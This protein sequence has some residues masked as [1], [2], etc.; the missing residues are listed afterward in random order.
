MLSISGTGQ[1]DEEEV[2]GGEDVETEVAD[3]GEREDPKC[4]PISMALVT[5][6]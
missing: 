1:D 3:V 5:I 2:D 6:D 4:K